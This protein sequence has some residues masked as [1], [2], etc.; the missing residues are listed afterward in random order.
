MIGSNED[1]CHETLMMGAYAILSS[2]EDSNLSDFNDLSFGIEN[3]FLKPAKVNLS[4]KKFSPTVLIRD[5]K[6]ESMMHETT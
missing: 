5:Y 4:K 3:I 6:A 2:T 1:H